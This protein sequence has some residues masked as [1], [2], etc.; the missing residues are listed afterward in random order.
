MS[1]F[2]LLAALLALAACRKEATQ[3]STGQVLSVTGVVSGVREE[4]VQVTTHDGRVLDF[5]LDD[6]VAITLAGGEAQPAVVAEGAPVRVSYRPQGS[7]ADLV[8][9]DVEPQATD[10]RGETAA[11]P[12]GDPP[13][14]PA[15]AARAPPDEPRFPAP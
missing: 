9:I 3:E 12:E 11:P 15:R 8:S 10:A 6:A 14:D 13:A 4:A 5:R 2:V 1:R 7:G